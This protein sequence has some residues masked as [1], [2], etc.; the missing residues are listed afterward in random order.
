[1]KCTNCGKFMFRK[2]MFCP[3]CGAS[4]TQTSSEVEMVSNAKIEEEQVLS[5]SNPIFVTP[6]D[7]FNINEDVYVL[8]IAL[9]NLK[10][11]DVFVFNNQK[12]TISE[13]RIT[14]SKVTS[15]EQG[16]NCAIVLKGV[17]FQNF[18][19]QL[20]DACKLGKDKNQPIAF[21]REPV[22]EYTFFYGIE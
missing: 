5:C 21:G 20:Q 11:G 3:K 2:H 10:V 16:K 18:K 1:M 19:N 8:G 15:V 12:F 7:I 4:L 14:N 6:A 13:L 17:N 22:T 9:I